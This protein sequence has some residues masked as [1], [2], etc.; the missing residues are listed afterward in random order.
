MLLLTD[1]SQTTSTGFKPLVTG[2]EIRKVRTVKA[3]KVNVPTK[4]RSFVRGKR[5]EFVE[6][7]RKGGT[8][9]WFED[10]LRC[11]TKIGMLLYHARQAGYNIHS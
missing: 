4:G 2:G 7:L 8:V 11:K 6:L 10:Q 1:Q 3:G 9:R 5:A